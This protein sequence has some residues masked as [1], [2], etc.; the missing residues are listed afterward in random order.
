MIRSRHRALLLAF[1]FVLTLAGCEE[2]TGV[3]PPRPIAGVL[4][5][6]VWEVASVNN[7]TLSQKIATRIIGVSLEETY[8]DS[9]RLTVRDDR[10]YS[11]RAWLRVMINGQMDRED[12]LVDEGTINDGPTSSFEFE[13]TLRNRTSVFESPRLGALS[14]TEQFVFYQSAPTSTVRYRLVP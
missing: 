6:G 11:Q 10:T 1:A 12:V 2:S 8:L 13:S 7:D 4:I 14:S 9:I 5:P 3:T